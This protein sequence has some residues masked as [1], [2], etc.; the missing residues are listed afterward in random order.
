MLQLLGDFVPQTP[1]Q[2]FGPWTTLGTSVPRTLAICPPL[3]NPTYATVCDSIS[4][5]NL[6]CSYSLKGASKCFEFASK[7][8]KNAVGWGTAPDS[9]GGL[10]SPRP[11]DFT[12]ALQNPKYATGC[13]VFSIINIQTIT[14]C[15]LVNLYDGCT[16]DG[17]LYSIGSHTIICHI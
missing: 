5:A 16:G 12:P 15:V 1:C 14:I 17:L 3:P 2:G 8:Q 6:M 7:S 13:A 11:P 4:E 10:P 9:A